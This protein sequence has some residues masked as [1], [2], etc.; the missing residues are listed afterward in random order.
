MKNH[1]STLARGIRRNYLV[2]IFFLGW[3]VVIFA[4]LSELDR[5][6]YQDKKK[7][8]VLNNWNKFVNLENKE[9][10]SLAKE[11]LSLPNSQ[12][13]RARRNKALT[14]LENIFGHIVDADNIIHRMAL[15]GNESVLRE[16][17]NKDKVA[18]YNNSKN[19][20]FYKNFSVMRSEEFI[21]PN[22]NERYGSLDISITTPPDDINIQ[23]LTREWRVWAL[24]AA[25]LITMIFWY[26]FKGIL[27]PVRSVMIFLDK[28]QEQKSAI[29]KT[30]RSLLEKE[31]NNLSRDALIT[32]LNQDIN[33]LIS[34]S[35]VYHPTFFYS[36]VPDIISKYFSLNGIFL[37]QV[38]RNEN[39]NIQSI[40]IHNN[41]SIIKTSLVES[42]TNELT[43]H[44]YEK[45]SQN[46]NTLKDTVTYWNDGKKD[47]ATYFDVVSE[48][49]REESIIVGILPEI[50]FNRAFDDWSFDT[51]RLISDQIRQGIQ[52]FEYLRHSFFKEKREANINLAGNL[53]HDL[54]N[55][56]ATS[57]LDI[58]T[59]K[60]FLSLKKSSGNILKQQESLFVDSVEGLL[61][62][63][64]LLQELVN[65]YRSFS[66]IK[67][68]FFERANLSSLIEETVD[69]FNLSLSLQIKIKSSYSKELPECIIDRR[70][71]KLAIFNLLS[72]AYEAI[73][74]KNVENN[75]VGVIEVETKYHSSTDEV[76]ISIKD[77]GTGILDKDK[78]KIPSDEI[79]RIF[80]S[81]ISSKEEE[82]SGGLGLNWVWAIVHDF[83]KGKVIAENLPAEGARLT[84]F[85]RSNITLLNKNIEI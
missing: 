81:G 21:N 41:K 26:I 3:C 64:K 38:K 77:N 63:T 12:S 82:E 65:I 23:N 25:V 75:F 85:L 10:T 52:S 42:F 56:I 22:T 62:N 13:F 31:F 83:H 44:L 45:D 14:T 20:L 49:E 11:V 55:I 78:N 59:I 58:L 6:H 28:A 5:Q 2:I 50:T 4:I 36:R 76:E 57:K 29:I 37:I 48:N 27:F 39:A 43:R 53:G 9:V 16:V 7:E 73:K 69:I 15:S 19:S 8:Y 17:E 30:P 70:L 18:L 33:Q 79:D 68:P 67:K 54:T 34:T 35:G 32:K 72:N 66:Y 46:L 74:A 47:F 24:C 84:I 60:D 1:F 71:I 80:F 40:D 51:C 61:N